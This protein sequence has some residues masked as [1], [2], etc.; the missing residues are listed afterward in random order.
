MRK[1]IRSADTEYELMS[2][3]EFIALNSESAAF[4]FL[5]AAEACFRQIA[6][7]PQLGAIGEFPITKLTGI[8]RW[9]IREFPNYLVFYWSDDATVEILHVIHGAR[10]IESMS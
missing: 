10:D 9:R 1:I 5:E 2:T 8:R 4:R 3:A 7:T 6:E